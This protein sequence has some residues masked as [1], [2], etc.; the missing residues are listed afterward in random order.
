MTTGRQIDVQHF[1]DTHRLSPAQWLTLAACFLIVAADGFDTAA[2]GFIAPAVRAEWHL[3]AA[4][5]APV[6]GAGLAGLMAGALLI[7]PLAD[8]FGRK[9]ILLGC[10]AFFG[11]ASLASA[12]AGSLGGLV[13]LRF[14]TGLGLG[15]AMPNAV[16]LSSEYAPARLRSVLVTT[17]F[18]GFTLGSALGGVAAAQLVAGFG[19]RSVL[20]VGGV[21]P[22]ALLPVIAAVLPESVRYLVT[23]GLRLDQVHRV[24]GRIA[25][26]ESLANATFVVA[27]PAPA[28]FPVARLFDAGL[29]RGTL[30]LWLAFFMSLLV[31]YL[32]SSWLPTL[33]HATGLSLAEAALVTATFQVGG[34]IGAIALGR[35][36]DRGRPAR[37]LG[38]AYLLAAG[39]IAFI[40]SSAGH[41]PTMVL[42]VFGAGFC[43]SGAQVGANALAAAFY[44]TGVRATGVSWACGIGRIGSVLGSMGGGAM[45]ALGWGLPLVFAVVG[46]PALVAGAAMLAFA[47]GDSAGEAV[48]EVRF[49]D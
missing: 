29:R 49:A 23:R 24:L 12:F 35:L 22:L 6:F 33:V 43:V 5:L 9:R 32:L 34:T 4:S 20:V 14:L 11:L 48:P 7:G 31:I 8:R 28:G 16:T 38:L 36:M 47:N 2:I 3:S 30:L 46:L 42:A 15:G 39:F 45:L 26:Q 19:W 17:M 37:V 44:P 40:G 25:P 10:V 21:L 41:V 13:A 27:D 18:C 1:I